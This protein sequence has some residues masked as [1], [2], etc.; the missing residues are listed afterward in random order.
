MTVASLSLKHQRF[1]HEYVANGGNGPRAYR[2]V[3][4]TCSPLAAN[5]N[6]SRLLKNAE[7]RAYMAG[8]KKKL[9]ERITPTYQKVFREYA[10]L[11][12]SDIGECLDFDTPGGPYLLPGKYL[13]PEARACIAGVDVISTTRPAPSS[14]A[15]SKGKARGKAPAKN[16]TITTT[17]T[18]VRLH[19]KKGALKDLAQH[20]GMFQQLPPAE[21]FFNALPPKLANFIRSEVAKLAAATG[22]PEVLD[23]PRLGGQGE[24][25]TLPA[26]DVPGFGQYPG[27]V[28][29]ALPGQHPRPAD[30][31]RVSSG[32][33]EFRDGGEDP[34]PLFDDP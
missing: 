22:D 15:K 33:Q 8:A 7:I 20:I 21:V 14:K 28:A 19:D 30:G 16:E 32:G 12:F 17:R 27:S 25:D 3:Y 10:K 13:S 2:I 4:P 9:L 23:Q 24:T 6:A 34:P 18:R 29:G 1:V 26:G 31:A 11:A 5:S